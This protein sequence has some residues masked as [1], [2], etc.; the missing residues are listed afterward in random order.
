M[1]L[2]RFGFFLSLYALLVLNQKEVVQVNVQNLRD[3]Y[4][5]LISYME[6]NGYSETYVSR[7]KRELK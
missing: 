3:N 5:K 7:F 4:P 2:E 6:D 1:K